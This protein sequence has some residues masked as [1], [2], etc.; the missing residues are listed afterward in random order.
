MIDIENNVPV[1]R[2][3]A[4][5]NQMRY[6]DSI[7]LFT[8]ETLKYLRDG[9]RIGKVEG[10]IG[11]LL[12]V[13]PVITVTDEGVYETLSKGFG[14]NRVMITMRKILKEKFGNDLLQITVHYGDNLEKA[15]KLKEK[16]E[17]DFNTSEVLISQLTP[18]L[19]IHTGPEMYAFVANRVK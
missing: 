18:V 10:T 19:G 14:M 9:G 1:P 6:E 8:V 13:K 15:K 5:L 16:L 4:N 11:D 3:I 2:I 7:A 12:N 17:A